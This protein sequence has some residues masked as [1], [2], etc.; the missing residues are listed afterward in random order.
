MTTMPSAGP[1]AYSL[2]DVNQLTSIRQNPFW[3][4]GP[5]R[6]RPRNLAGLDSA[7]EP[8]R[9]DGVPTRWRTN[10][11]DEGPLPATEWSRAL[12][13]VR[14]QQTRFWVM[15]ANCTGYLPMNMAERPFKDNPSCARHLVRGRP[16]GYV[17]QAGPYAGQ[18]WSHLFNPGSGLEERQPVPARQ[19]EPARR[20]GTCRGPLEGREDHRLLPV[21]RHDEPGPGGDRP[22]GPDQHRVRARRTSR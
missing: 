5:G 4:R 12:R 15:P 2:N 7:V 21:D 1:Y 20:P 3:K 19:A 11:L 22:P 14:R 10:E 6:M 13:P 8:E 17:A 9:A 18:P 16:T